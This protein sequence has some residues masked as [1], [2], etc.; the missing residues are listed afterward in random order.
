LKKPKKLCAILVVV[1]ILLYLIGALITPA[2]ALGNSV[3]LETGE[4]N[5]KGLKLFE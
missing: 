3:M 4:V 2:E 1:G 5:Y